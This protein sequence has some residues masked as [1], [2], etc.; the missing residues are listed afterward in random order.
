MTEVTT[1]AVQDGLLD[2]R[3]VWICDYSRPDL[4]KKALRNVKP[5]ECIV[6]CNEALHENKRIYYSKSHYRVLNKKGEPAGRPISPVDN[7]GFRSH[8]GN[9]LETFENREECI[10]SWNKMLV[11]LNTRLREKLENAEKNIRIEMDYIGSMII[12]HQ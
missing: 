9:P 4:N 1:K 6:V 8:Q 5:T 7:T 2:G 10:S 11:E 12:W 3:I